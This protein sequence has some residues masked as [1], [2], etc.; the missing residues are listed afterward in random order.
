[1]V[2]SATT[3]K[4]WT[5]HANRSSHALQ[6]KRKIKE[7]INKII[8]DKRHTKKRPELFPLGPLPEHRTPFSWIMLCLL[9]G[10]LPIIWVLSL[11]L[12]TWWSHYSHRRPG[13][14]K[15]IKIIIRKSLEHSPTTYK[16]D[17]KH[18]PT[19]QYRV[20]WKHCAKYLQRLAVELPAF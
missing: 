13:K 7:K 6:E 17:H 3:I 20:K 11:V 10:V 4:V 16:H 5:N 15:Q 9:F 18:S 8:A 2:C 12:L 14:L 1:M 19:H